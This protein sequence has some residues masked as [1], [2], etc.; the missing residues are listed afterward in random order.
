MYMCIGNQAFERIGGSKDLPFTEKCPDADAGD[1]A[2]VGSFHPRFAKVGL[3]LV[4]IGSLCGLGSIQ[5][6]HQ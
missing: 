4:V 1:L 6:P 2:V 5:K 3:L